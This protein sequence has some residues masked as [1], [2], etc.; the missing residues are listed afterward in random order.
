MPGV[1]ALPHGPWLD[2]DKDTGIDRAG[3]ENVLVPAV[4]S[5]QGVDGYNTVVVNF[6]KYDGTLDAD[7]LL[8]MRAPSIEE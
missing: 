2:I 6:E 3:N 8:P 4:T 5:G 7:Y 1:I